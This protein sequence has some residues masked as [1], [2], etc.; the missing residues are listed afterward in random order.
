MKSFHIHLILIFQ[1]IIIFSILNRV[2]LFYGIL[3]I[4][5]HLSV[6]LSLK[7]TK[8]KPVLWRWQ[9][10]SQFLNRISIKKV[11]REKV[12]AVGQ[13]L[14]Q[15]Q[16]TSFLQAYFSY[17]CYGLCCVNAIRTSSGHCWVSPCSV[18]H[19][20][21]PTGELSRVEGLSSVRKWGRDFLNL[22]SYCEMEPVLQFHFAQLF[23]YQQDGKG[24]P[25]QLSKA[26]WQS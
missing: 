6:Q 16:Y 15:S 10:T 8:D 1:F 14:C 24:I 12:S 13:L 11:L 23:P 21:A 17:V 25:A 4:T 3:G 19:P 9:M 22:C 26:E 18:W 2:P 20:W 5:L 7:S